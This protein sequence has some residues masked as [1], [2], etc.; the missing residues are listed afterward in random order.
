[1][2]RAYSKK[3]CSCFFSALAFLV[4]LHAPASAATDEDQQT[5]EMFYEGKDLA[6]SATRASK[7]ISRSAE[8]ITIVTAAEIEMMGAHT[9]ADVLNYVPGIQVDDRGSIGTFS[10]FSIQGADPFQVLV[11]QDGITLN[12]IG[13]GIA[14]ISSIPVQNIE[15]IEIV[16]GPGSSSW[17]S[18][19]GGVINIV[20]K[21]PD[22][23]KKLG[24]TLA[25]SAGERGTRDVRGEASGTMGP[26]GYYQY[27][28]NLTSSG[29]RPITGIDAN[30]LY[31]KLRWEL[32]GQG[33][34][35]FTL[36]YTRESVGQGGDTAGLAI[37]NHP[38]TN[39]FYTSS[40]NYPLCK[41]VDLDLTLRGAN[42]YLFE[43]VN[44]LSTG[45]LLQLRTSHELSLGGSVKLTWRSQLQSLVSGVDF[46]HFSSTFH[47]SSPIF[48]AAI[49]QNFR[50]DKW[51]IFLN[52]TFTF[53]PL[54]I[55]GG[56]RYDRMHPVGD[57]ISPSLGFAWSLDDKTIFR[58][59]AAR[60]YSLPVIIPGATQEKVW[61]YQTGVE[62]T[63][64]PYLWLKTSLFLNYIS[65]HSSFASTGNPIL[66]KL[67]KQGVE[68]EAKTVPLFNTFLSA[69][70]T[71]IDARDR[72]NNGISKDIPRQI[73]KM[74]LH[75]DDKRTFRAALLGRYVFYNASPALGAKDSAV[76]W[77]LNLA[78]KIISVRDMALELFFNAHN[79]FNDAQYP[80]ATF[81]NAPR[82]LEGGARFN[83]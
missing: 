10:G 24:G 1:M 36:G 8:N 4:A 57:F 79:L 30:Y 53:G 69:G 34:L 83:F 17:G 9:L 11:M 37:R 15:R 20:T 68:V 67:K 82:W 31:S 18:A 55:T 44:F 32:P 80:D 23:E 64:I 48:V 19:L 3:T 35:L 40:L 22:E 21:S 60:G 61:A 63:H 43:T 41:Q 65:D 72:D 12:F 51:G 50:S 47:A 81:K 25:F 28:E 76:V 66:V 33:S 58:A 13:S 5:L 62:T 2:T 45:D 26:L 71:F 77:D 75:Y 78:K 16:K 39:L 27:A 38:Q 6:V 70:Y 7:P 74:G 54:A 29:M 49:D 56:I 73:V 59:Y 46:D 14:S 52:D 42:K